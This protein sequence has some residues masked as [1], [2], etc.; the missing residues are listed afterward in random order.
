[1]SESYEIYNMFDEAF[2][3]IGDISGFA[4]LDIGSGDGYMISYLIKKKN[5]S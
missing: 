3:E 2:E 5:Q 1:V 4:A